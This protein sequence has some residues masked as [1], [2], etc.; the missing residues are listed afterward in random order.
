MTDRD[1]VRLAPNLRRS[2]IRLDGRLGWLADDDAGVG[3]LGDMT[4]P[5]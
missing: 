1:R 4:S 3:E 5:A 2:C